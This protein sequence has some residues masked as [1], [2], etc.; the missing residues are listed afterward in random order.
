MSN[1]VI[2]TLRPT[3]K[4]PTQ[5][6]CGDRDVS[7]IKDMA[8]EFNKFFTNVGSNLAKKTLQILIKNTSIYDY[9]GGKTGKFLYL[10]PVDEQKVINT[11]KACTQKKA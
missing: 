7:I 9:L 4:N 2:R 6:M 11:T 3:I 8:N 1:I 5:I 10:K